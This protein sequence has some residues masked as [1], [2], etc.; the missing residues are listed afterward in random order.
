MQARLIPSFFAGWKVS[1]QGIPRSSIFIS[2]A[3]H[4]L[5]TLEFSPLQPEENGHLIDL[6]FSRIFLWSGAKPLYPWLE[7]RAFHFLG[8]GVASGTILV[9]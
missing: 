3:L 1:Q 8:D 2:A 5:D 9:G 6:F 7:V 4:G